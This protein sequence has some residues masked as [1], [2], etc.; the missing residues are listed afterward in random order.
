MI[1]RSR[2]ITY[3]HR[4]KRPPQKRKAAA[5]EI[6]P[7]GGK[8]PAIVVSA[9]KRGPGKAAA[10]IDDGQGVSP[11]IKAFFARIMRPPGA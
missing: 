2:I 1:G 6:H 5:I 3:A 4:P 7:N 10:W 9:T 11:E 8:K